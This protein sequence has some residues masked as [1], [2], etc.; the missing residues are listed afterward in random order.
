MWSPGLCSSAGMLGIGEKK[1]R[2]ITRPSFSP[3]PPPGPGT[4]VSVGGTRTNGLWESK[5][6]MWLQTG[7]PFSGRS[8]GTHHELGTTEKRREGHETEATLVK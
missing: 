7:T 8:Q 2:K 1:M 5:L 6:L 3:L 4:L